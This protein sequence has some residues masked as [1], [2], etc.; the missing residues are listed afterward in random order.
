MPESIIHWLQNAAWWEVSCGLLAENLAIFL[1]VVAGGELLL[2]YGGAP[3]V[4]HSPE[5]ITRLELTVALCNVLL[6]TVITLVGWQLWRSGVIRFRDSTVTGVVVDVVVLLLVMDW[7]MYW[8]HRLAHVPVLFHWIHELHHRFDKVRPL[9]LFA[10]NPL[11][12]LGFGLLWLAVIAVY[13]ASWIGMSIYLVLNVLCGAIGHLGV[14]PAPA[15]W[16]GSAVTRQIAGSSFHAQHHQDVQH[17]FGF[18]TLVW[19][20]LF[21]TLRPG[22]QQ[23]FGRIPGDLLAPKM[24]D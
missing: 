9:T 17:N 2:K 5:P 22:Y 4:S 23:N 20:R 13:P 12:N 21:G 18:Y 7:C 24:D 10:L 19:D 1:L 16:V 14:E 11:E 3:V 8:L 15:W 6:N